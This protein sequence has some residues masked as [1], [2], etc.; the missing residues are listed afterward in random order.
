MCVTSC[1]LYVV[2]T[3]TPQG[4]SATITE[5]TLQSNT[6]I[7]SGGALFVAGRSGSVS[8]TSTT[9]TNLSNSL[10]LHNTAVSGGAV[11]CDV[12][13]NVALTS[14]TIGNNSAV[15]EVSVTLSDF[16]V[17]INCAVQ[18]YCMRYCC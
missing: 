4:A 14:C 2:N 12:D 13:A 7:A 1:D 5:C 15:T 10:L 18:I 6:A 11:A 3:T 8:Q 17:N 16:H 9:V